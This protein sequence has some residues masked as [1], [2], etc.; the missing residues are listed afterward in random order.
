MCQWLRIEPEN[1]WLSGTEDIALNCSYSSITYTLEY[2]QTTGMPRKE[3]SASAAE[4]AEKTFCSYL[5]VSVVN[6]FKDQGGRPGLGEGENRYFHEYAC[7]TSTNWT[8]LIHLIQHKVFKIATALI[9]TLYKWVRLPHC[10][11][12]VVVFFLLLLLIYTFLFENHGNLGMMLLCWNVHKCCGYKK[13]LLNI[14][15]SRPLRI[16]WPHMNGNL[17]LTVWTSSAT[18]LHYSSIV[19]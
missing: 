9:G 10:E 4:K 13:R 3:V 12:T 19:S 15:N 2:G 14:F 18:D 8:S 11:H 1:G 16:I 6:M 5:E 7:W 17:L